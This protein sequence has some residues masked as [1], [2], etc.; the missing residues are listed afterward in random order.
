MLVCKIMDPHID[1]YF[2][3]GDLSKGPS[4]PSNSKNA[5]QTS[6]ATQTVETTQLQR[7]FSPLPIQTSEEAHTTL[8][9]R[10]PPIS[11]TPPITQSQD[12]TDP[13]PTILGIQF[14]EDS[15]T[16]SDY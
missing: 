3:R 7:N 1:V 12:P 13:A 9:T 4:K 14:V 16:D 11:H 8:P 15:E 2:K 6:L 10:G 5:A